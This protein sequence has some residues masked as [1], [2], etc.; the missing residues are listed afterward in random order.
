M[1]SIL[2]ISQQ[3][4][5]GHLT[6][7]RAFVYMCEKI[8]LAPSLF[9]D[10]GY[11]AFCSDMEDE[12][13][14]YY[15]RPAALE[16]ASKQQFNW[17]FV[18]NISKY[19]A[20]FIRSLKIKCPNLRTLFWYHEPYAGFCKTMQTQFTGS[21][22]GAIDCVKSFGRHYFV[23]QLLEETDLVVL[24]SS[25]AERVF[26]ESRDSKSMR[27][28][29]MP[30]AFNDCLAD[31]RDR[32]SEKDR[33]YF[34]FISTVQEKKGFTEFLDLVKYA[35]AKNPNLKFLI[36]TRSDVE[37]YM[38]DSLRSLI[39]DGILAVKAGTPLTD[40]EINDAYRST[41]CL[42][43]GYHESTQSGVLAHSFMLGT[44]VL[45]TS[46]PAFN[47]YVDGRNGLAV[48]VDDLKNLDLLYRS[49]STVQSNQ[50]SFCSAARD[51]F[52]K[53]FDSRRL[54]KQFENVLSKAIA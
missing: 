2:F 51:T 11:R 45:A 29:Q 16:V 13:S 28:A 27:V 6:H 17:A 20:S 7:V 25:N 36:A 4:A 5:P 33:P 12:C 23:K 18:V 32:L 52:E 50:E 15:S 30:L 40:E 10:E 14:I 41:S 43:L 42:W 8:G 38:D 47:D 9:L 44:P 54:V 49:L 35:S 26:N 1:K 24:P 53:N 21:L 19:D 22:E 48:S 3:F 39:D 31:S 46:L 34:S 37:S